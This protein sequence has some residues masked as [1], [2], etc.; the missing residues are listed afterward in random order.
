MGLVRTVLALAPFVL[1][2]FGVWRALSFVPSVRARLGAAAVYA[3]VPLPAAAVASGRWG[4]LLTYGALPWAFWILRLAGGLTV[5]QRSQ[6]GDDEIADAVSP[7]SSRQLLRLVA[8]LALLDAVIGAFVPAFPLVVVGLAVVLALG[9]VLAGGSRSVLTAVFASIVALAVSFVVLQP[10]SFSLLRSDGW[11]AVAGT[12]LDTPRALGAPLLASFRIGPTALGVAALALYVPVL[13]APLIGR[14]WRLTWA[15]RAGCVVG[16]FLVLTLL[17]DRGSLPVRLPEPGVMLVPVA[18]GLALSAGCALAGFERDIRGAR[19]GWRQPLGVLVSLGLLAGLFQGVVGIAGGRWS[20]PRLGFASYLTQLPE[21][22]AA[23]AVGGVTSG[24][25]DYRVAYVGDPRVMPVAAHAWRAGVSYRVVAGPAIGLDEHFPNDRG[26]G[27]RLV[28]EA[29][30]AI[31]R[32]ARHPVPHRADRRCRAIGATRRGSSAHRP[33]RRAE[34]AA[35]PPV[36]RQPRSTGDLREHGVAPD[37]LR[38]RRHRSGG[39]RRSGWRRPGRSGP[40]RRN[41]DT[42]GRRLRSGGL[43]A[44]ARRH[45]ASRRAG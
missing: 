18:L 44:G 29:L 39:E 25:G 7:V 37:L 12:P 27:E 15:A 38:A 43:R 32:S 40:R 4:V 2:P 41:S 22:V 3:V 5:F 31:A 13:A 34:S 33:A 42:P 10:W 9:T 6:W 30:D 17:D 19:F 23:P 14:G 1:G 36:D 21:P 45:R 8:G 24:A 16:V 26:R 11:N 28:E 35:R 20:A